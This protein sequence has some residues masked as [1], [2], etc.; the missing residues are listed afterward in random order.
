MKWILSWLIIA[1]LLTGSS[2]AQTIEFPDTTIRKWTDD[3]GRN[4]VS[5]RLQA[6]DTS[7]QT[8]VL[9]LADETTVEVSMTDLSNADRR[10][11]ARQTAR[12]QRLASRQ[13][14]TS[15]ATAANTGDEEVSPDQ[16]DRPEP[17]Q[18]VR[19]TR[20]LYQIDWHQSP[21]TAGLAAAGGDGSGDDRPVIW[22]RVLG[23]LDGYM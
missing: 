6:R 18:A 9:Q 19:G 1:L 17:Q 13:Q 7:G 16:T 15:G 4:S 21:T 20:R 8:V 23:A 22:F 2:Q 3:S 12:V 11:I 10:Y 14:Q 5:A